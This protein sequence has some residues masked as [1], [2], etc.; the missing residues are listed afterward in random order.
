MTTRQENSDC[1]AHLSMP[2]QRSKTLPLD[3]GDVAEDRNRGSRLRVV[4]DSWSENNWQLLDRTLRWVL[5][6]SLIKYPWSSCSHQKESHSQYLFTRRHDWWHPCWLQTQIDPDSCIPQSLSLAA[7][8]EIC[9]TSVIPCAKTGVANINEY[10]ALE[11]IF[12]P[13]RSHTKWTWYDVLF[14]SM[15]IWAFYCW[16]LGLKIASDYTAPA[17]VSNPSI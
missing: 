3:F 2:Q 5:I 7:A 9:N 11:H 13:S 6:I 12:C 14:V 15:A 10:S 8:T 4:C 16:S 1:C 17:L